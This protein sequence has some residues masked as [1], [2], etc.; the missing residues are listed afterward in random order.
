MPGK[1]GRGLNNEE[2]GPPAGPQPREPEPEDA[3][4]ATKSRAT[5][6]SLQHRQLMPEGQDLSENVVINNELLSRE[7]PPQDNLWL[8]PAVGISTAMAALGLLLL[9]LRPLHASLLRRRIF[10][11]ARQE[12]TRDGSK[13]TDDLTRP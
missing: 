8:S 7:L 3:V 2:A 1:D 11:W 9:V 5:D 10:G 6:G 12:I 13:A 4:A